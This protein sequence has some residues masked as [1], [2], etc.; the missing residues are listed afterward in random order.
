MRDIFLFY[1]S[2]YDSIHEMPEEYRLAVY[3][4]ICECTFGMK[5][6]DD[7][8]FPVKPLV[9][10]ML[11]SVTKAG[12]RYNA[13]V[14]NGN[15][16]GR[17]SKQHFIPPDVWINAIEEHGSIPKAAKVL[18]LSPGTLYNWVNASSDSKI[19]KFKNLTVSDSVSVS[20]SESDSVS[21]SDKRNNK[22]NNRSTGAAGTNVPPRVSEKKLAERKIQP[23]KEETIALLRSLQEEREKERRENENR[24]KG[25]TS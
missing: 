11:V 2:F 20:V 5:T 19:Q 16:G 18:G 12:E 8:S 17:P 15:R 1:K 9:M 23:S 3:D 25:G 24:R 7:L 6:I 13:S 10:Q 14:E 21:D 22:N 4:A